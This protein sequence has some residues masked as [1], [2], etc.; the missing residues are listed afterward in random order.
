MLYSVMAVANGI[1]LASHNTYR[2]LPRAAAV[3]NLFRA[4]LSIP[5]ALA[6]N[7]LVLK[8]MLLSGWQ[9]AAALLM[10]Q[11]WA[12][13][14]AKVASD[15]MAGI[16]EGAAD[17]NLNLGLR[18]AD[19]R[20]KIA[21]VLAIHGRLE[22]LFPE[23]DVLELLR[24]GSPLMNELQGEAH[25]LQRRLILNALDLMYF[26]SFQ[27]RARY[28]ARQMLASCSPDELQILLGTQRILDR[29][30][31]IT[32]MFLDHLVGRK[33][34]HP[35]AFY[36]DKWAGYLAEFEAL[37]DN[38]RQAADRKGAGRQETVDPSVSRAA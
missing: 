37:A 17:R 29:E 11:K 26:W 38:V 5:V 31:Q 23:Q 12:A 10:L 28:A 16:I 22:M 24:T 33:F 20:N 21:H 4:V 2:G 35:L 1:Y 34:A 32:Q 13:I 8:L 15:L 7:A 3:G 30:R 27:P 9:E 19:Y 25:R 36:L 14:I 6:L 18:R